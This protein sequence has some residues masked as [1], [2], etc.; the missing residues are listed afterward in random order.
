MIEGCVFLLIIINYS[1][2]SAL[3]FLDHSFTHSFIYSL[4]IYWVPIQAILYRTFAEVLRI[5][6]VVDKYYGGEG[7]HV[8]YKNKQHK[9]RNSEKLNIAHIC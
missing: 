7:K 8:V 1:C 2:F 4:Y 9:K 6:V 3:L 5:L